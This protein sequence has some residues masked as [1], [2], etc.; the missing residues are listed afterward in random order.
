MVHNVYFFT[1]TLLDFLTNFLTG[2]RR[3]EIS[4]SHSNTEEMHSSTARGGN[5][6][7]V[8]NSVSFYAF[9]SGFLMN[10]SLWLYIRY[11]NTYLTSTSYNFYK[12]FDH[13]T[14]CKHIKMQLKMLLNASNKTYKAFL[15]IITY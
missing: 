14:P 11:L 7:L 15:G 3:N 5:K 13:V 4:L 2:F 12:S 8:I 9:K 6:D 10:A 1:E